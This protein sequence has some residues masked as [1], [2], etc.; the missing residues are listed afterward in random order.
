VNRP[1]ELRID[2]ASCIVC[3]GCFDLVP[4]LRTPGVR[5]AVSDAA[6]D[7][8]AACPT[9]AIR[10]VDEAASQS[11]PANPVPL[12][13]DLFDPRRDVDHAPSIERE[14]MQTI[15][16]RS[17]APRDRHPLIFDTFDALEPGAAFELVNDHDPKPLYHQLRA[18]RDGQLDWAYLVQGPDEWRVR[19]GR[20][21]ATEAAAA[22][23]PTYR[24]HG[25]L[26]A[27]V[28][29]IQPES[30]VSRQV[31][32]DDH[33]KVTLFGFAAGQELSEHTASKPAILQVLSGEGTFGLGN[34]VVEVRAGSWAHMDPN[35]PHTVTA[36]TPLVLLLT[37]IKAPRVA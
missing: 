5:V 35:L 9:G 28:G 2:E 14:P 13:P 17:I 3:E 37:M 21:A 30:I 4:E 12:E 27:L 22:A 19:I 34:E 16:V 15:D 33:V 25:D 20:T 32:N 29:E 1:T 24:A 10:W 23:T 7:A 31:V 36:R 18:E 8:M 26:V 11:A 6:L